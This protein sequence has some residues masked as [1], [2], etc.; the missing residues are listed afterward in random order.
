MTEQRGV[1]SIVSRMQVGLGSVCPYGGFIYSS[2]AQSDPSAASE[3]KALKRN[4][5]PR[6]TFAIFRLGIPFTATKLELRPNLVPK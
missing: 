3:R 5:A 6:T 1:K 2:E 4:V